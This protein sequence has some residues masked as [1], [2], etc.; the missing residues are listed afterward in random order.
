MSLADFMTP[1]RYSNA[2]L[3]RLVV[4]RACRRRT[5]LLEQGFEIFRTIHE[6]HLGHIDDQEGGQPV[7]KEESSVGLTQ[8]LKVGLGHGTLVATPTAPNPAAQILDRILQENDEVRPRYAVVERFGKPFI[9][10]EFG[11]SQSHVG[12]DSVPREQ[13]RRNHLGPEQIELMEALYL[14]I[15]VEEREDLRLKTE[16]IRIFLK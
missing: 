5:H 8:T 4:S 15:S 7:V 3:G 13:A 1:R 9:K 6:I 16:T 2:D 12:V 14:A 10:R 11:V